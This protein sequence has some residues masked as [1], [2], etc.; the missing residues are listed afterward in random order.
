LVFRRGSGD[1]GPFI[2]QK[3][4]ARELGYRLIGA[5]LPEGQSRVNDH[6]EEG[7][8][9]YSDLQILSGGTLFLFGGCGV[10]YFLWRIHDYLSTNMQITRDFTFLILSAVLVWARIAVMIAHLCPML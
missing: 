1:V 6:K 7:K 3:L 9:L 5:S 10:L 4:L 8:Y 2:G